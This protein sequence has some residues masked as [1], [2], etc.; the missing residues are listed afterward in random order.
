MAKNHRL[1]ILVSVILSIILSYAPAFAS[2]TSEMTVIAY[3]IDGRPESATGEVKCS[4]LVGMSVLRKLDDYK[5]PERIN[6]YFNSSEVIVFESSSLTGSVDPNEI[7]GFMLPNF[8]LKKL[9]KP[10]IWSKLNEKCEKL[11]IKL[12]YMPFKPIILVVMLMAKELEKTGKESFEKYIYN[13]AKEKSKTIK[14]LETSIA[15]VFAKMPLEAQVL[16]V[17]KVINDTGEMA[18]E[19]AALEKA[20]LSGDLDGI[21]RVTRKVSPDEFIAEADKM[22]I[23]ILI[24]ERS[25]FWM[26]AIEDH[27]KIGG[28]FIAVNAANMAGKEG[29]IERLRKKGYA[30]TDVSVLGK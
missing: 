20:Y 3:K 18:L 21:D 26:P 6:N 4:Y 24:D 8:D 27:I 2:D 30:L 5:I 10:D 16:L 14:F 23:R 22:W 25:D 17:E 13:L 9:F 29:L 19:S 12:E 1:I 15:Y 11:G 28:A 7:R